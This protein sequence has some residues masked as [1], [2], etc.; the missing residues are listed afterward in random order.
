M[1]FGGA[2]DM[3]KASE[4]LDKVKESIV[5]TYELRV[6]L[7][8]DVISNMMDEETWMSAA[9]AIN[10]GFADLVSGQGE[11]SVDNLNKPWMNKS[12]VVI[13]QE[14]VPAATP[15]FRIAARS[16]FPVL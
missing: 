1:A 4:T 8:R 5:S 3:V 14:P 15:D 9:E 16:S 12:P 7:E 6:E 13:K 11:P 10:F 2:S